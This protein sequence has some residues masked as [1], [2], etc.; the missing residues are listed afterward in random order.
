MTT[1]DKSFDRIARSYDE[2]RPGYP[3]ELY[4]R[5]ISYGA[6]TNAERVLEIGVGTGKAT[7]PL[8]R[9]GYPITGVEPG[10]NLVA[11]ARANLA[12]FPNVEIT[13]TTFEAWEVEAGAFGLAFSAQAFHWLNA[14]QRLPRFARA[15]K[16]HGVLALFGHARDLAEGPLRTELN[17]V[18]ER[19]APA[20][21][22]QR[23][24]QSWYG[25]AQ[26]P[27]MA[28]LRA[29]SEFSDVT[30]DVFEWQR[31]LDAASYCALQATYS[32]HSTL[33]PAQLTALLSA[34]AATIE[35]HGGMTSVSYKTGLFLARASTQSEAI[36]A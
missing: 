30:F 27:I 17:A 9:R 4:D 19:E 14:E 2:L 21:L 13:T 26:S 15:L 23:D 24:D 25:S 31:P 22:R 10:E 29:S 12:A 20:L 28:E 18:Y 35:A 1:R 5:I 36:T 33:P 8:A 32:D 7:P 6:L 34:V 3:E 11:I 16:R